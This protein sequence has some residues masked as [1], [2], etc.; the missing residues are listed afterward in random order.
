M[1][2]GNIART[3]RNGNILN[4]VISYVNGDSSFTET[5]STDKV[6]A[7]DWLPNIIT[8]RLNQLNALDDFEQSLQSNDIVSSTLSLN[9]DAPDVLVATL[10]TPDTPQEEQAQI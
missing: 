5:V 8:Q 3:E 4:I 2:T 9:Q 7:D 1:W 6:Q 10:I